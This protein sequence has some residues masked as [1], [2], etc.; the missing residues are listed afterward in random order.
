MTNDELEKLGIRTLSYSIRHADARIESRGDGMWVIT[1][2]ANC[3]SKE[4]SWLY[5]PLPSRRDKLFL[6]RT[7][8]SLD[9]A[10]AQALKFF[11][12]TGTK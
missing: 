5:E 10:V 11:Y 12:G 6:D 7:R 1:D 8:Y 3:L 2:G 4:G 9:D